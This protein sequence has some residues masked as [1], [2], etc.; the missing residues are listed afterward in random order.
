LVAL[1]FTGFGSFAA[2]SSAPA[3]VTATAS[4]K[5]VYLS[6]CGKLTY[7]PSSVVMACGDAGLIAESLTWSRWTNKSAVGSGTGV[8]KTCVPDCASGGTTSGPIEVRATKPR[9]C[10]NG[11]HVFSKL[12]YFWT[13]GP[14]PGT[15][16]GTPSSGFGGYLPP[17]CKRH[18]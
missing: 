11:R 16:P 4:G 10:S 7:Q 9:K 2:V 1:V 14:P 5:R 13:A 6:N 17:K 12:H 18:Q 8:A 3:K 15:F